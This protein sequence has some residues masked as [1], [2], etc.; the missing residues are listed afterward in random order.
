MPTEWCLHCLLLLNIVLISICI[1][2]VYWPY[3][4]TLLISI[5]IQRSV[6]VQNYRSSS[7]YFGK[8]EHKFRVKVVLF[9]KI[10][11]EIVVYAGLWVLRYSVPAISSII[12]T[13]GR[14]K[15]L[16]LV[17]LLIKTKLMIFLKT[18][19][20]RELQ[21]LLK[22]YNNNLKLLLQFI[23]LTVIALFLLTVARLFR[24]TFCALIT[25]LFPG[26]RFENHTNILYVYVPNYRYIL[27]Y[28]CM[29]TFLVFLISENLFHVMYFDCTGKIYWK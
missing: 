12:I 27:K 9:C 25:M 24:S 6:R 7:Y 15:S 2:S 22:L 5:C 13:V 10:F 14:H 4:L 1:Y 19:L 28:S 18:I 23:T 17:A 20:K 8:Y 3:Y 26:L 16:V 21:L 29:C 11:K